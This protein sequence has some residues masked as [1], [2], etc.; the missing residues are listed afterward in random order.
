MS[1]KHI[2]YVLTIFAVS[3]VATATA[4]AQYDGYGCAS[5]G[6]GYGGG[7]GGWL[8]L[9]NDEPLVKLRG[10]ALFL[11]RDRPEAKD[12]VARQDAFGVFPFLDASDIGFNLETGW[13]AAAQVEMNC[14]TAFEVRYFQVDEMTSGV[15]FAPADGYGMIVD[16]GTATGILGGA[17]PVSGTLLYDSNLRSAE[18][19]LKG[20]IG[21]VSLLA[22][23]RHVAVDEL[24]SLNLADTSTASNNLFYSTNN[25]LYGFQVGIEGSLL[26]ADYAWQLEGVAKVG[27]YDNRISSRNGNVSNFTTDSNNRLNDN[28]TSSV[29]ELGMAASYDLTYNLAIRVGLQLLWVNNIALASDQPIVNGVPNVDPIDTIDTSGTIFYTGIFAGFEFTH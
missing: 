23:F 10:G 13:E 7:H 16:G 26:P 4:H 22:G 14:C 5:C 24:L 19:N 2:T 18:A 11:H 9:G 20:H 17:F 27:V 21:Q 6:G 8:G 1:A 12:L 3:L 29:A 28:N 15:N 25:E